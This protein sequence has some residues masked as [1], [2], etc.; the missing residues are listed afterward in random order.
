MADNE[1]K[2]FAPL[3]QRRKQAREQ[4]QIAR[5]H[6]LTAAF[7]FVVATLAL[8]SFAA[9]FGRWGVGAFNATIGGA[10]S[11]EL[12]GGSMRP[13]MW[14]TIATVGV[15]LA[16]SLASTIG[17]VAQ[18]GLVFATAR[19]TPDLT[20]LNPFPYFGRMFAVPALIELGK[21][22]A[23]I[24][25]IA[26]TAWLT[27]RHA[28]ELYAAGGGIASGLDILQSSVRR[29]LGW[30][31]LIGFIVAAADYAAKL[32]KHENDLKM[33]RQEF[34]DELKQEEGNPHVKRAIRR[35]QRKSWKKARG[36]H[37]AAAA[38]VVLTN[39]T[40]IAVALRYRRGY[41]RAP[42]VVAKGAGEGA[43]RIKAVARLAAVP[44]LEN[45]PLAR[46]LFKVTEVGDHI[47]RQFY[48]AIA[49]VLTLV[50]RTQAQATKVA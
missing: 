14:L 46:A 44:V 13:L 39:P 9:C 1:G 24:V 21:A 16:L 30:S 33:T 49:E 6:D 8:A 36:M 28:F 26:M 15:T 2:T 5:S 31:A 38:T 43:E 47:P 19:L 23:K 50:M 4:G 10:R 40:H 48:R 3:P 22:A 17:A 45:K 42:L 20:R 18:G 29:L 12:A 41:D 27:A 7:S 11:G 32:Y 37:Q 35:A 34:L 25:L